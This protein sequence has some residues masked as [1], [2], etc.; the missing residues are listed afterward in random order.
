M[1]QEFLLNWSVFV[2]DA[3]RRRRGMKLT[4]KELAALAKVSTPTVSRFELAAKDIQLSSALAILEALGM[5]DKRTLAF[6]DKQF[7]YDSTAGAT[8]WGQDGKTRQTRNAVQGAKSM[9]RPDDILP[10]PGVPSARSSAQES[11]AYRQM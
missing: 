10:C 8:F 9:S 4:Q 1:E 2:E 11:R 5:T 7:S 3:I 6:A